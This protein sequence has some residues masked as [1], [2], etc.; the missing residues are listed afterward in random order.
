MEIYYY[1]SVIQSP[2]DFT[3]IS[4][5]TDNVSTT[6]EKRHDKD[7]DLNPDS[8]HGS[9]SVEVRRLGRI[10]IIQMPMF[11][12]LSSWQSHCESSPGSFD[13][14]RTAPSG[15]RP[16]VCILYIIKRLTLL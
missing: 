12:V 4:E 1:S 3:D 9:L 10:L 16:S 11:M 15:R 5:M 8:N 14:C 6:F 2:A 7:P 13:E